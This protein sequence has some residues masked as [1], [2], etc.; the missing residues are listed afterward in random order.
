MQICRTHHMSCVA[1]G[2]ETREQLDVLLKMDCPC[3]QGYYFDRPLPAG[4][5]AEK[6]LRGRAPGVQRQQNEEEQT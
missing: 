3:A 1:E 5:F 6:Y 2:V 4:V